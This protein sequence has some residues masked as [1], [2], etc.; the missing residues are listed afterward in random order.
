M[1]I[2]RYIYIYIKIYVDIYI[3]M[4]IQSLLSPLHRPAE[5][6]SFVCQFLNGSLI[7]LGL[8]EENR[9]KKK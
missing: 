3:Y 5:R 1:D 7:S 9:N 4:Y 2:R 6:E 8:G